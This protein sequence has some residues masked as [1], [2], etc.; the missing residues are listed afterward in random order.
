M[1][2]TSNYKLNK[3]DASDRIMMKDFNDDNQAIEEALT[4]HDEALAEQAETLSQQVNEVRAE[5]RFVLLQEWTLESDVNSFTMELDD[6]AR[7]CRRLY[8]MG[9]LVPSSDSVFYC[10]LNGD[11]TTK[12]CQVG[13]EGSTFC[14]TE[15]VLKAMGP[16]RYVTMEGSCQGRNYQGVSASSNA[17]YETTAVTFDSLQSL[18]LFFPSTAPTFAAGSTLRLYGFR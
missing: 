9:S 11:T 14:E 10:G 3:W 7:D 1:Q 13:K 17:S 8:L 2:E 4:A 16:N 18:I 5:N 6:E 12:R 15:L